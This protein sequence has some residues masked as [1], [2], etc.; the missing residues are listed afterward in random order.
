MHPHNNSIN[1]LPPSPRKTDYNLFSLNKI[2]ISA[3]RRQMSND[4]NN[5]ENN[6]TQIKINKRKLIPRCKNSN[7]FRYSENQ[8]NNINSDLNIS[9]KNLKQKQQNSFFNKIYENNGNS[10]RPSNLN[11]DTNNSELIITD[12]NINSH[13]LT[14]S[15]KNFLTRPSYNSN[16]VSRCKKK[17]KTNFERSFNNNINNSFNNDINRITNN[18]IIKN[19]KC[20]KNIDINSDVQENEKD[21]M[22]TSNFNCYSNN[23]ELESNNNS[24][25]ILNMKNNL[26]NNLNK[27]YVQISFHKKIPRNIKKTIEF[28]YNKNDNLKDKY[29]NQTNIQKEKTETIS[30]DSFD[31]YDDIIDD[32]IYID[33]CV[34]NDINDEK[35]YKNNSNSNSFKKNKKKFNSYNE[36]YNNMQN[37]N[38]SRQNFPNT[39]IYFNNYNN[40]NQNNNNRTQ[41]IN[42]NMNSVNNSINLV[43]NN[44]NSINNNNMNLIN[45]PINN[46]TK[47]L[48]NKNIIPIP[49]NNNKIKINTTIN[50]ILNINIPKERISYKKD[51]KQSFVKIIKTSQ[52][53]DKLSENSGS[54]S[55]RILYN[56]DTNE[57]NDLDISI[58]TSTTIQTN[59]QKK[60]Y[61]QKLET[62]PTPNYDGGHIFF[63]HSRSP[64]KVKIK[65]E[66]LNDESKIL[67][68][69]LKEKNENNKKIIINNNND[70]EDE[71]IIPNYQPE[72]INNNTI[73]NI[74]INENVEILNKNFI[75]SYKVMSKAGKEWDGKVKINQD[76]AIAKISLNKI[77]GINLFGILDGHG[78]YGHLVSKLS[79]II[80]IDQIN[81]YLQLLNSDNLD[82][83]YQ[84]IKKNNFATLKNIYFLVD[85]EL[86]KQK[87]DI[88]YSGTTCLLILQIGKKLICSNVG[89]S[90]GILIYNTNIIDNKN[91]QFITKIF[92]LSYDQKPDLPLE[93]ERIIKTGGII[94][95]MLDEQGE[96]NGPFRVFFGN[97]NFPGLAMSRSLGDFLA[98][99]CGVIALPEIIEYC[100][101]ESAKFMVLCS[102]GV[103]E[104]L[105]NED[106]MFIGNEYYVKNDIDG[107][108][109]E[110][111]IDA[112][113]CWEREDVIRDDIT[114]VVVFF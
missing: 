53:Y 98:K 59:K 91:N 60:I 87:Y 92:Q 78:E 93:K 62:I 15:C 64:P 13:R 5:N 46:S 34:V 104:F 43:N 1:I 36:N 6:F 39:N 32:I 31:R 50:P 107:F 8:N 86:S 99:K 80:I 38:I 17:I 94:D 3:R 55:S 95:Q 79:S 44:L 33:E 77:N 105:K 90:R 68:N 9:P 51:T 27:N 4:V 54:K 28:V 66:K 76:T 114:S 11:R 100:L 101:D 37:K 72:E 30:R 52:N 42:N 111:V 106:V 18:S 19:G 35:I 47:N 71:D 112:F 2:P 88:T 22:H 73:T 16:R 48:I 20:L 75:K 21:T 40:T 7:S 110:L 29:Q 58:K 70:F 49:I 25:N 41:I 69:N 96:K 109:N 45:K 24:N 67:I 65:N 82:Y 63:K 113:Q 14:E 102:D 108:C 56:A 12:F 26:N 89:D 84:E 83:I 10:N 85:Q 23:N 81:K 97:N 74:N 57:N 61:S 103:W